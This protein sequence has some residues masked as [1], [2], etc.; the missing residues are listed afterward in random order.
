MYVITF[1]EEIFLFN[2]QISETKLAETSQWANSLVEENKHF[3]TKK[4]ESSL[5]LHV[6][7]MQYNELLRTN[8][9]LEHQKNLLNLKLKV[10]TLMHPRG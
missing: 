1:C 10:S 4:D 5:S 3:R 8:K 7:Q 9:T 2:Q 6:L